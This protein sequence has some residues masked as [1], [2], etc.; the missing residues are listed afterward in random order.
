MAKTNSKKNNL[1]APLKGLTVIDLTRVLA[2]PYST[3]QLADLGARVI[4]VESING[5]DSRQFGPFYKNISTYFTSLNRGKESI[6][7][8]LKEKQDLNIFLKLIKNAD[9]LVENFRPGT[10]EKLG[11]KKRKLFGINPRL[12]YASCSGFGQTGK[13]S[14]KPAYDL[15]VQ[16]LGGIMSLTGY[17]NQDPVR[18]GTSI[19]DITAGLFTTIG[20]QSALIKRNITNKGCHIDISM[21][22]CQVAILENAVSRYFCDKKVPKKLGSR[23]P[24]I[25]PFECFKCKDNYIAIAAGNN[26]LFKK[27]C[28][29]LSNKNLQELSIFKTNDLRLKNVVKLKEMLEKILMKKKSEYWVKKISAHGVPV[30]KLNNIKEILG[31]PQILDRNMIVDVKFNKNTKIKVS[32]NPIKF[33]NFKDARYRK[34]APSLDQDRKKILNDFKIKE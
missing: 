10:M 20:I 22:D 19:G 16:A 7:L 32:G 17:E 9:I 8:N 4:K 15:I 18:V 2:G 3:M 12:I 26:I 33:S 5:D 24:S 13:L 1:I 23:H 27:L 11:L 31:H 21:L 30:S 34:P 6:H 25:A 29:A 14:T 28:L